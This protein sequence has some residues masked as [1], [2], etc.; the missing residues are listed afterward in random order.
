MERGGLLPP[1]AN[2]K[3]GLKF[4]NND[5]RADY[6]MKQIEAIL[7]EKKYAYRGCLFFFP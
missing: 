1:V 6:A 7:K 4:E 2:N 5:Q 3:F